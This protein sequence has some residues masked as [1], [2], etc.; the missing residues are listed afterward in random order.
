MSWIVPSLNT[1]AS[2][3][4]K[5]VRRILLSGTSS[6]SFETFSRDAPISPDA[7][8]VPDMAVIRNVPYDA[9][10]SEIEQ[11]LDQTK[12]ERISFVRKFGIFNGTIILKFSSEDDCKSVIDRKSF[13]LRGRTCFFK[14]YLDFKKNMTSEAQSQPSEE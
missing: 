9:S 5:S 12:P 14:P 4:I 3:G 13:D 6:R 1:F 7:S 10:I 8:V 2:N 11:A